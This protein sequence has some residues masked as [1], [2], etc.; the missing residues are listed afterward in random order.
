MNGALRVAVLLGCAAL[1]VSC[2]TKD[3]NRAAAERPARVIRHNGDKLTL[4]QAQSTLGETVRRIGEAG[5]HGLVL[6]KGIEARP[7]GPLKLKR[8]E[9]SRVAAVLGQ[10]AQCRVQA[11]PGYYFIYPPGYEVLGEVSLAGKLPA[12][13]AVITQQAAFGAGV[14]LFSVFESISRAERITLVADNA[15]A[16]L[17][18]GE[19]V[20]HKLPLLQCLEAILKSARA[21]GFVVDATDEYIFVRAA[22][23]PSPASTLLN[24]GELSEEQQACLEKRVTVILPEPPIDP[25]RIALAL[26]PVPLYTVLD[27]LSRQ[28]GVTVYA[29]KGLE[30]IPVNPVVFNNVRV[31]TVLDL[32]IR[33][34][35]VA[36]FGYE[37]GEYRL[38]ILLRRRPPQ[39]P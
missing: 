37:I 36:D 12:A 16:G 6:M 11:N 21:A 15:V 33:Q 8:L 24:R 26:G 39:K 9:I 18:C 22:Q 32:L 20:L 28:L 19:L 5:G 27:S 25:S 10:S 13:G 7:I 14:P 4:V 1:C 17:E 29:E 31:R 30:D 38:L 2:Q 34:W 23:N 35:P 3:Q